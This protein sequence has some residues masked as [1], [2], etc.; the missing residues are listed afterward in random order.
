MPNKIDHFMY[1]AASLDAGTQWAEETFGV[2]PAYGGEHVGLGTRNTLL[3]LGDSYLEI[4]VPDP[5][6]D[7][8]GTFGE[9]LAG[10]SEPGMVTW[11]VQ[12]DLD[13]I[14][15]R[16]T[17]GGMQTVGPNRTERKTAEGELMIWKLLFPIA[18]SYGPRMPFF[19]DWMDC[20]HPATTNPM[21]GTFQSMQVVTNDAAG[22][23]V[24]LG[25]IG[26]DIDV[27]EGEPAVS[28][29]IETERGQVT[30]RSTAETSSLSMI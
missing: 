17:E 13:D 14:S 28:V 8:T 16:L 18:G 15:A 3:S 12:G 23:S 27:L 10:L 6:Q 22:L 25:G 2:T 21:A 5:A 30:L 20:T 1:A 11:A 24:L 4:I 29:D 9:K 7:L 26:L 19:I